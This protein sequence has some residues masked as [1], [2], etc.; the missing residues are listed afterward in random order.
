MIDRAAARLAFRNRLQTL[1]VATTGAAALAATAAGYTRAAGSFVTDDF[2]PGQELSSITGFT[3]TDAGVIDN[4]SAQL[5]TIVGGRTVQTSGSGRVLTV[6]A[7]VLQAWENVRFSPD[8]VAGRPYLEGSFVPAT[9]Q[10]IHTDRSGKVEETGLYICKYYGLPEYAA[11]G[12]DKVVDAILA[13]FAPGTTLTAGSAQLRCREDLA[14][15]AGELLENDD[16]RPVVTI[17][18]PWRAFTQNAVAP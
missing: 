10:L 2:Q 13:L 14:A 12:I 8:D 16:G 5:L 7:P 1:S 3:Q 6:G 15:F 18:I 4:V 9:K 17:T 11:I